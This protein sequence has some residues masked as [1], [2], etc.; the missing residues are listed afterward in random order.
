[1]QPLQNV[2]LETIRWKFRYMND[3]IAPTY[4]GGNRRDPLEKPSP[5][6]VKPREIRIDPKS[7]PASF[8]HLLSSRVTFFV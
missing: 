3:T 8:L 2:R 7:L 5:L 4:G 6:V 1:M